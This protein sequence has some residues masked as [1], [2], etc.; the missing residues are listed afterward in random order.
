MPFVQFSAP[1][2]FSQGP[3]AIPSPSTFNALYVVEGLDYI[4]HLTYLSAELAPECASAY[5]R[6]GSAL[7]YQAQDSADVFGGPLKEQA[8]ADKENGLI[9]GRPGDD[10]GDALEEEA[11]VD[12]AEEKE[13][14]RAAVEGGDLQ[15][16]WENLETARAIWARDSKKNAEQ[17]SCE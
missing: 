4:I 3:T 1:A 9:A 2:L 11:A 12:E 16:A 8:E 14:E 15:L 13:R 17:L 6:Y 7:L 10:K 5:Y